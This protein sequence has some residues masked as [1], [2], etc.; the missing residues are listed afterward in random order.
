M[1]DHQKVWLKHQLF[2]CG[3]WIF[4]IFPNKP[5]YQQ[6]SDAFY[7]VLSKFEMQNLCVIVEP[8]NAL[9]ASCFSFISEVIDVKHVEKEL[10]FITTNGS[11]NDIDPFFKKSTYLCETVDY[12]KIVI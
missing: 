11:R 6:Y 1:S 9:V 8:G 2:R 4:G 5:T 7:E 10:W 3:R 12:N